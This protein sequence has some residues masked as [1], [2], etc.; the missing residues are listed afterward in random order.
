LDSNASAAEQQMLL[1]KMECS[2]LQANLDSSCEAR[3]TATKK[4]STLMEQ[5]E[6]LAISN[7]ELEEKLFESSFVTSETE[8]IVDDNVSLRKERD[9]LK[10]E[11][12][13][14]KEQI[15]ELSSRVEFLSLADIASSNE[16][17]TSV[18]K[19][20]LLARIR[21]LEEE[22]ITENLDEL[23]DEL[24]TLHEE[25]QQLDLDNEELLV[26]LG[27]MQQVKIE[28][29][30]ECEIELETLR[31]QVIN[32]QDQCTRL[33]NNLDVSTTNTLSLRDE[34]QSHSVKMLKDENNSLRHTLHQVSEENK[35]L[36]GRIKDLEEM[37]AL[38]IAN[39]GVADDEIK[40]LHQELA[41]LELKLANK[42]EEF[43][44]AENEMKMSLDN[45]DL[46]I[47]KL[48]TKCSLKEEEL[49][50]VS[51]KLYATNDERVSFTR[52]LE[53]LQSEFQRQRQGDPSA[54]D[55]SREEKS[56]EADDDEIS[57][58]DILADAVLDS[59]DYLRSQI[60][61][62]AQALQR[63]ELQRA[64]A[65]ERIFLERKA[66]SDALCQ[67]GESAR[68]FYSTVR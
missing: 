34:D 2:K 9:Q 40:E 67:L 27:L 66:N 31:E 45:R 61:V 63:S 41:L 28:T 30:A 47:N 57:L 64:D 29:Q 17:F 60:V 26:Q 8:R 6:A 21:T 33:Q 4:V 13:A 46:E 3:V 11:T 32:L 38:E 56:Y 20:S 19:E 58:Q 25:R 22:L 50:E 55:I 12:L 68:R 52:Q 39:N 14:L 5:L 1:M 54:H 23:R 59:D 49:K 51:S 10:E 37:K 53:S 18:E 62:L 44:S 16:T 65:L 48:I 36:S 43:K 35:S 15:H 24:S 7:T 42:E